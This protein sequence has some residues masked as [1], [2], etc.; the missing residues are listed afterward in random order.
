[1]TFERERERNMVVGELWLC[2]RY[3]FG[4][5]VVG[6]RCGCISEWCGCGVGVVWSDAL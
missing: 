1:M 6:V 3:G 5:C 4:V 2:C